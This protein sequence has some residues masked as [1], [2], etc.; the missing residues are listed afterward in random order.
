MCARVNIIQPRIK[1]E[2]PPF[3]TTESVEGWSESEGIA[4]SETGHTE[5]DGYYVVSLRCGI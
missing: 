2:V 1:K 5:K 3:A 4:P